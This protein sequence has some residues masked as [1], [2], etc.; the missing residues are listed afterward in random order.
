MKLYL[1]YEFTYNNMRECI[2][3]DIDFYGLFKNKDEAIRTANKRVKIG[4]KNND[5]V[6]QN[7]VVDK[8]NP[9]NE[10]DPIYMY[11]EDYT[12]YESPIYSINIAMLKV[13]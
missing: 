7:D 9:F 3:E 13:K 4:I 11:R 1:V 2:T 12:E 6:I 5:V 10:T 8:K